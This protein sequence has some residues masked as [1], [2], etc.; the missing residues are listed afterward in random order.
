MYICGKW[1][2]TICK[3]T[4]FLISMQKRVRPQIG[5]VK[6]KLPLVYFP[7]KLLSFAISLYLLVTSSLIT[8]WETMP[9]MAAMTCK[10]RSFIQSE[11]EASTVPTKYVKKLNE[12]RPVVSQKSRKGS[13]WFHGK[14]TIFHDLVAKIFDV[15]FLLP[16]A[17]QN[18]FF[19]IVE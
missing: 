7:I 14:E 5:P 15:A 8:K 19:H 17:V 13:T 6:K 12:V 9:A 16:M 3:C 1:I 18:D 4:I 2:F 10:N 11:G